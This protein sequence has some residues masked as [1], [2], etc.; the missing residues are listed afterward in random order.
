LVH[1][2]L[3][4]A[5]FVAILSTTFISRF[6]KAM[7]QCN[8]PQMPIHLARDKLDLVLVSVAVHPLQL[9]ANTRRTQL[10]PALQIST[11]NYSKLSSKSRMKSALCALQQS[12]CAV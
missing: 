12:S 9:P 5:L 10:A 8:L 7:L 6:I 4:L 3:A 1:S 11:P 2:V